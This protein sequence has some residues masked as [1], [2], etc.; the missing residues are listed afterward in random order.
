MGAL[1][2]K[3]KENVAMAD[4][5]RISPIQDLPRAW[6]IL[7]DFGCAGRVDTPGAYYLVGILV[8]RTDAAVHGF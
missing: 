2:R 5:G 3:S 7:K 1:E 8:F 6:I 4:I